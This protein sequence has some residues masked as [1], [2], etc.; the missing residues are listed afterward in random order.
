MRTSQQGF[1]LI[2]LMVSLVLGL[3]IVAA[4]TMLFIAGQ[5][6]FA[7]QQGAADIQDNANFALN[8]ITKDIRMANLNNST[9]TMNAS[10]ANGGIVFSTTNLAGITTVNVS[11]SAV[12]GTS[13]VTTGSDQLTIQYL[14]QQTGGFDCEGKEITSTS[15]YVIQRYF[16]RRDSNIGSNETA[17]TALSL[18]CAAGR[19]NDMTAFNSDTGQIIMK[20]VDYFRVLLTV[21]N[22]AGSL[23]DM[24]ISD[25]VTNAPTARILGVKLGVLTRSNQSVGVDSNI[26]LAKT[27][28]VLDQSVNLNSTIQSATTKN[29]RQ[30]V[31]QA[32][33]IRNALGGR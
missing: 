33:A 4:A 19:S 3:I 8:Y 15:V 9:A 16:V 18:V 30:V 25:Y 1:T 7:L 11:Q 2:E 31:I 24:S 17:A 29:L 14:P 27:F 23:R 26:N 21:Q 28:K 12:S 22:S 13:N 6:S 10:L 32:V 20:R 5:K